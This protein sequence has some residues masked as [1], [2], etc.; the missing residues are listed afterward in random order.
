M[1]PMVCAVLIMILLGGWGCSTPALRKSDLQIEMEISRYA[2]PKDHLPTVCLQPF[3][4]ETTIPDP[5]V[6]GEAK[7]G[8][9]Y[10]SKIKTDEP[11]PL[12]LLDRL[13]KGF[14]MAGFQV[15]E[16]GNCTQTISGQI[17]R[18]WVNEGVGTFGEWAR[19]SVRYD[20]IVRDGNGKFLWGDTI[21]GRHVSRKK[22]DAT[23]EDVPTLVRALNK[24]VESIFRS[25]SFWRMMRRNPG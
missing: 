20:L 19:A 13:K 10:P 7:I 23:T 14:D 18:L 24:S 16:G 21:E 3:A 15:S 1:K 9:G 12:I 17:E 22:Y 2:G 5:R 8:P 4:L 25:D 11:I 6:V